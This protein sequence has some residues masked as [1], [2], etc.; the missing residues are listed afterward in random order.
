LVSDVPDGQSQVVLIEDNT[1]VRP[2]QW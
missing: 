2:T 1:V